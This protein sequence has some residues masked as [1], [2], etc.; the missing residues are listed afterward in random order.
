MRQGFEPKAPPLER[1]WQ[2]LAE[3]EGVGLAVGVCVTPML[4]LEDPE[5]FADGWRRSDRMCW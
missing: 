1:R 4:P 2:A 5:A 3:L